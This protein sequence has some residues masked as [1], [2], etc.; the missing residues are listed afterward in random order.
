MI[1]FSLQ[2]PPC[3]D[4]F[5]M[6]YCL[7]YS[8]K[9]LL[10]PLLLD[11]STE[12]PNYMKSIQWYNCHKYDQKKLADAIQKIYQA[13]VAESKLPKIIS[14]GSVKE[15]KALRDSGITQEVNYDVFISY[16]HKN[17]KFM[18]DLRDGL[19][20]SMSVF[21]DSEELR[22]GFQW[23]QTIYE[24][25][26]R[27]TLVF[28]LLSDDYFNSAVCRE[29]FNLAIAC[30]A[31]GR[32]F[33]FSIPNFDTVNLISGM[34]PKFLVPIL[35]ADESSIPQQY[36]TVKSSSCWKTENELENFCKTAEEL[37]K[38]KKDVRSSI[39]GGCMT[40]GN[41]EAFE[42]SLKSSRHHFVSNWIADNPS[43]SDIKNSKFDSCFSKIAVLVTQE[44]SEILK[45]FKM[46]V[47]FVNSCL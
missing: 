38:K 20:S 36:R 3:I 33:G 6:S 27:S 37:I 18:T 45:A 23:Q 19:A 16:A 42:D 40:F 5:N 35:L 1:K 10:A 14:G 12:L 11:E 30:T 31:K 47:T 13:F 39:F 43:I 4:E 7:N 24:S 29:E 32:L 46:F 15:K 9:S 26:E 2:E 25:L 28:A 34:R 41:F 17:K 21:L 8:T 22:T 44:N